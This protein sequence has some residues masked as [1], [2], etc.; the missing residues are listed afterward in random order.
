MP[1]FSDDGLYDFQLEVYKYY[2]KDM[3]RYR[4][5]VA[6]NRFGLDSVGS[7]LKIPN[8]ELFEPCIFVWPKD[9]ILA[10]FLKPNN[11]FLEGE[12][13]FLRWKSQFWAKY[14]DDEFLQ[15]VAARRYVEKLVFGFDQK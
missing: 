10:I 13:K 6:R 3:Q 1:Y 14:Q 7:N 12:I 15:L 9:T 11:Q 2:T 5:S 8:F 4:L